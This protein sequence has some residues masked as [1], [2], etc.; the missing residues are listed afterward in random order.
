MTKV[1]SVTVIIVMDDGSTLVVDP[2]MSDVGHVEFSTPRGVLERA[3][4][5][6]GCMIHELDGTAVFNLSIHGKTSV[7]GKW[8]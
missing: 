4:D 8:R 3:G 5:D 1:R 7:V 2:P 6:T